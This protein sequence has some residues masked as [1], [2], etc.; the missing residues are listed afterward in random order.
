MHCGGGGLFS[1]MSCCLQAS[2]AHGLGHVSQRLSVQQWPRP[3]FLLPVIVST[4]RLKL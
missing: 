3:T 2:A 1:E 4:V